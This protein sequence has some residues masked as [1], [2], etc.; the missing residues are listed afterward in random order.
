MN[1]NVILCFQGLK[2]MLKGM[3]F[4][5]MSLMVVYADARQMGQNP[6]VVIGKHRQ[7]QQVSVQQTPQ[8]AQR[9]GGPVVQQSA[10]PTTLADKVAWILQQNVPWSDEANAVLKDIWEKISPEQQKA[11][12]NYY[13][14][15]LQFGKMLEKKQKEFD[16]L[17]KQVAYLQQKVNVQPVGAVQATPEKEKGW[18]QWLTGYDTSKL[19]AEQG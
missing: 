17:K 4:L 7:R 9:G 16:R 12:D 5:A 1:N 14:K 10:T 2:K 15:Q 6:R 19:T 8:P 11:I 13:T 3:L 18:I